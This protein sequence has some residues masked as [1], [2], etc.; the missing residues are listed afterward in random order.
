M[1]HLIS[2]IAFG[3]RLKYILPVF[4]LET[5]IQGPSNIIII[6]H[7]KNYLIITNIPLI[8]S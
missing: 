3:S 1:V 2:C 7:R 5:G 6:L 4:Y 8:I